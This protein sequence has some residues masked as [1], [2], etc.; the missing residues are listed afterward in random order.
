MKRAVNPWKKRMIQRLTRLEILR[1][2]EHYL[3][4]ELKAK[5][6]PTDE[7]FE[8]KFVRFEE[9]LDYYQDR[10]GGKNG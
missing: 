8:E 6:E 10:C 3:G 7:F 2:I 5:I 4:V 9:V 1:E